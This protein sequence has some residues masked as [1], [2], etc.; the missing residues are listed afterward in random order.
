MLGL[1]DLRFS[2]GNGF[3]MKGVLFPQLLAQRDAIALMSSHIF[4]I[5]R[6]TNV[7]NILKLTH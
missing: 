4:S 2:V 1:A 6:R 5:A 7:L 3:T